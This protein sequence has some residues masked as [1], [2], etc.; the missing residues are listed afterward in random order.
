MF[1]GE[2]L[3][4][5]VGLDISIAVYK[6]VYRVQLLLRQAVEIDERTT[7]FWLLA[8]AQEKGA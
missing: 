6:S 4:K 2:V 8:Q 1:F 5:I 7:F 3:H